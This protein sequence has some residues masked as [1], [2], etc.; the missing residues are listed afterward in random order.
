MTTTPSFLPVF[1]EAYP[2]QDPRYTPDELAKSLVWQKI[3]EQPY[4]ADLFSV[5]RWVDSRDRIKPLLGR[6]ARPHL[7]P[8]RLGQEPTLAFAASTIANIVAGEG[9]KLPR[10]SIYSFGLFGPNG[11]LPLHLT[12][13]ARDRLR[14]AGDPTLI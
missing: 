5:L 10:L 11:P 4:K 2:D 8:S 14:R 9:D 12:E 7:E 6:A 3:M 1:N 13:Y